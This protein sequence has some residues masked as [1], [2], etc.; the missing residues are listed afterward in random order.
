MCAQVLFD[1]IQYDFS[2]QMFEENAFF[3]PQIAN[4]TCYR[5]DVYGCSDKNI[6]REL[7]KKQI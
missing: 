1:L 5:R 2:L 6:K 7:E 4:E 3:P